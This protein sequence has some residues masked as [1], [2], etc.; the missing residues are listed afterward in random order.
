MH[1]QQ[2]ILNVLNV[3]TVLHFGGCYKQD[4]PTKQLHNFIGALSV[5]IHGG[6]ILDASL[7]LDRQMQ[8]HLWEKHKKWAAHCIHPAIFIITSDDSKIKR[9][10]TVI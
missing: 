9:D 4:P 6:I 5:V 1:Y 7:C 8:L 10:C 2:L 3:K